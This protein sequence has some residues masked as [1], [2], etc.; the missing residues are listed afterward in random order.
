MFTKLKE[1][2]KGRGKERQSKREGVE[3]KRRGPFVMYT[4]GGIDDCNYQ[5]AVLKGH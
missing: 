5:I 4:T 2:E 3:K 1:E